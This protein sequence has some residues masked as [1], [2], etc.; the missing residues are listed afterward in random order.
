MGVMFDFHIQDTLAIS[1]SGDK[2]GSMFSNDECQLH[3]E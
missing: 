2:R 3:C 1:W